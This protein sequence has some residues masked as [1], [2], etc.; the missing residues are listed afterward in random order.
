MPDGKF[1]VGI[2]TS[3]HADKKARK[4]LGVKDVTKLFDEALDHGVY[5]EHIKG[6]FKAYMLRHITKHNSDFVIYKNYVFW[7]SRKDK[8]LKTVYPLHQKWLKYI[9]SAEE[10]RRA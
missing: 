6:T 2:T 10:K 5:L 7:F 9:K 8:V 4:R 1:L 3:P